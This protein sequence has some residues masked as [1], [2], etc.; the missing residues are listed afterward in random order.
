MPYIDRTGA[1]AAVVADSQERVDQLE[2][3][4]QLLKDTVAEAYRRIDKN[5]EHID[6]NETNDSVVIDIVEAH[7]AALQSS[8]VLHRDILERVAKLERDLD[9]AYE[10]IELAMSELWTRTNELEAAMDENQAIQGYVAQARTYP[11]TSITWT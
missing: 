9:A 3:E 11:Y 8:S 7:N 1:L 5:A 6:R 4:T 2:A 10:A